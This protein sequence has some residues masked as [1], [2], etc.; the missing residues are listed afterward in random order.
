MMK[1]KI[2]ILGALMLM[3]S[4][5]SCHKDSDIALNYAYEDIMAF[6]EAKESFAGE[7][8]VF[9]KAMNS[10]YSLWD[11]E[12]EYGLDWDEHYKVML[13]KFQA[14]D[15]KDEVTDK[16]L[17]SLM[18]EMA[19]PLHDGHMSIEFLNHK[20]GHFVKVFPNEIRNENR[21]DY[22][23]SEHFVPDLKTY[24]NNRELLD[25]QEANTMVSNQFKYMTQ[26]KDIGYQWALT[27]QEELLSKQNPTE[28]DA[29]MLNYLKAFNNE[30]KKL[31]SQEKV[32]SKT[33]KSYNELVAQ[34]SFLNIPFLESISENFSNH[35]INVKYGLF[36]DN[37][38]Y[39]YL[40]DFDLTAY[41]HD[42]TFEST[43]SDSRHTTEVAKAVREVY[44]AW[45]GAIQ[46][47]HKEKKLKGVIIDLRSNRGG[48]TN[49]SYYVL[50]SLAPKGGL[51][52]GYARFKR[53]PGRFDYSPFMPMECAT[54]EEE[55]E[56]IDDVPI[57]ILINCWSV[58]MSEMTS[59]SSKQMPNARLIGRRSW[60]GL[61]ALTGQDEFTINYTGHIGEE[62]KTPVFVYLP[63][64]GIFDM[65]KKMLDGYGVEPDIEVDFD[66]TRYAN[67]GYDSQLDRALQY[68]RTGN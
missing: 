42:L 10:T 66:S 15:E 37:I 32:T 22:K 40:S 62:N 39:F 58:S 36:K 16:E 30:M 41:L 45:F 64:V 53:G 9:W 6:S 59:L 57:T 28:N 60:G 4:I 35:G 23:Q 55:H 13:P 3:L 56:V 2:M 26:T 44:S 21:P 54:M 14:L 65:N 11:Y 49:D 29:N 12:K 8:T 48:S 19:A 47:L 38:A 1:N 31:V 61:C 27:K 50:G 43:F 51:Q 17:E 68:I 5:T 34:F 18:K 33:I 67:T 52:Y 63:M 20:T 7:F 24:N 25:W 46:K